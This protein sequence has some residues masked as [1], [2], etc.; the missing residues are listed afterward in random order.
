MKRILSSLAAVAMLTGIAAAADAPT[1]PAP[2][3]D[4]TAAAIFDWT[5][6]YVGGHGGWSWNELNAQGLAVGIKP[7]GMFG[8]G[9][10]GYGYEFRNR[11]YAGIVGDVSLG[12]VKAST[13][14]GGVN[15]PAKANLFGTARVKIGY[16]LN[17]LLIYGT[18]G[19]A[20]SRNDITATGFGTAQQTQLGWAAGLGAET[21]VY[22]S[23]TGN[24]V[25]MGAEYVYL[26]FGGDNYCFGVGF[27]VPVKATGQ[28]ATVFAN[29]HW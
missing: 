5:G 28:R 27:C 10:V 14:V 7:D 3:P 16:N 20:W 4:K 29:Y 1:R 12:D 21:P 19:L 23:P 22:I 25:T 11:W 18:G 17:P 8:G 13:T 15:V 2:R 6:F 24:A 26:G 9:Q